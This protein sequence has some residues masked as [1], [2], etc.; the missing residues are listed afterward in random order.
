[1]LRGLRAQTPPAT[2]RVRERAKEE[3]EGSTRVHWCQC[4]T[5]ESLCQYQIR[6]CGSDVNSLTSSVEG[7]S[8]DRTYA[9]VLYAPCFSVRRSR[10]G[11]HA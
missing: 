3:G 5:P 10:G 11:L 2:A 7:D 8:T 1:M 4:C 9:G 6:T